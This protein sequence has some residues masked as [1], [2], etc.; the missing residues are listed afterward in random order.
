MRS[1]R[2]ARRT[3]TLQQRV[4]TKDAE[5]HEPV[6]TWSPVY[7]EIPAGVEPLRGR[8]LEIVAQRYAETEVRIVLRY[9]PNVVAAMRAVD[10]L[11]GTIYDIRAVIDENE[12]HRQLE[13]YCTKGVGNG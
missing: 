1:G 5:F 12:R 9:L 2:I 13:L 10:D 3:I 7:T 11:D 4:E 8:E 6:V